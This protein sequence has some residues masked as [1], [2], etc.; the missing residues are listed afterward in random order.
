MKFMHMN[1]LDLSFKKV[2]TMSKKTLE[3]VKEMDALKLIGLKKWMLTKAYNWNLFI[4]V[5]IN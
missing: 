3:D 5:V 2:Y 4:V 1:L